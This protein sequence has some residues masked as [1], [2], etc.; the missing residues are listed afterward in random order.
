MR[1]SIPRVWREPSN[2]VNDC[3]FCMVDIT[4]YKKPADRSKLVYPDIPSS[5]APVPH[6]DQLPVPTPPATSLADDTGSSASDSEDVEWHAESTDDPHFPDQNELDDLIRD[7][8]LSK[9]G[10]E[11]LTSRLKEWKLLHPSCRISKYRKRHHSFAQY[12]QVSDNLCFCIDVDG[13]F[14]QIGINHHPEEWRLFIDSSIRSLKG[15]LLHNGN[16]YP[17]VPVA[18][19]THL[20][21]DYDNVKLML[22]KINY[23]KYQWEVCGD[24]K[25]IAF[26][27]GLQGGFTKYSCFLCLWDSRASDQHYIVRDWPARTGLTVGQYNVCHEALILP[28]KVLLPPLHI[29]LG[30][31]KQFVVALDSQSA[32]F[33]YICFMFPKLSDAK[34]KAGVFTGPQIREM[35]QSQELEKRMSGLERI[36]W[37]AFRGVVTGFLGNKRN[38]N[39]TELVDNLIHSYQRLGCRMSIKLHFLHSHLDFFRSNLGAVSEES[40]ER[41]HQDILVMEKRYQGRWDE[42]MMG[43]YVWGL[44]R[45]DEV[46]HKRKCRSNLHF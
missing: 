13:L 43:D 25:M 26:L 7:L 15:V 45:C 31:A 21:E 27:L 34:L 37:Q 8:G 14:S 4:T 44:V 46:E 30:L 18:H 12:Y 16:Q 41:F 38:A 5:I 11:L 10:S 1:F 17:S 24:L 6:S 2:H 39:Y 42:A 20:K 9:A 40:G 32:A 19:S 23:G 33:Q 29:K 28:E 35:L 36:A 3:Y 22:E